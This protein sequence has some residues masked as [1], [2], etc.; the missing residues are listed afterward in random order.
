MIEAEDGLG[1]AMRELSERQQAFV[2]ATVELGRQG[3]QDN[4]LAARQAGYGRDSEG[5]LRV[6][7]H[8]L[9]HDPKIQAAIQEVARKEVVLAAAVIATPVTI[10]IAMN[11]KL[12]AKDR[13][14]ACEMLF[15]RGG[16]PQQTEHKVTVE[17]VDDRRM[18]EFADRLAAEL[19]VDRAK[20]IGKNVQVIEAKAEEVKDERHRDAEPAVDASR[21]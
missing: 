2:R 5:A 4:S 9:A 3:V 14:R 15:N 11:E 6:Q 17:H 18:L 20:L 21:G 16:M 19:G 1:P 8:R 13:L 7:A 12:P 10:S